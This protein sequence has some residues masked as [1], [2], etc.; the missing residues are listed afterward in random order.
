MQWVL[1]M[2]WYI[3]VHTN[4]RYVPVYNAV[5]VHLELP[6]GVTSQ[7]TMVV[8]GVWCSVEWCWQK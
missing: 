3:L 2:R 5:N 8:D 1:N 7:S 6:V 4:V